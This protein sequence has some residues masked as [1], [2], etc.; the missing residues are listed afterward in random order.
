[1]MSIRACALALVLAATVTVQGADYLP[2]EDFSHED[3][4]SALTLSPDG[5]VVVYDESIRG[6]QRL[7]L[8]DLQTGQKTGI[9]LEGSNVAW[10]HYTEFYWVNN[11]RVLFYA[12]GRYAAI[13]RDGTHAVYALPGVE[14]MHLFRDEKDGN[15]LVSG[16]D[17]KVG[18]GL[19]HV[20]AYRPQRP[21]IR[22][23]NPR[24]G[25]STYVEE[26]PGNIRGWGIDAEGN[27]K[28][29]LEIRGTQYRA[30]Y[31][32]HE[33]AAWETLAGM[34]WTDP[35]VRPVGFSADGKTLY[36]TRVTPEGTWGI[37]PYDLAERRFGEVLI[38]HA[39]YDIIPGYNSISA[40][41]VWHQAP[42]YSPKERE[43]LGFRYFT[44]YPRTFWINPE[45]EQV[46]K[47]IDEAL[48]DKINTIANM[49]DDRQRML[50]V[51]WTASDPG[52]Y[53]LFDRSTGQLEKIMARRPWI[54]PDNM[55]EV[56]PIRFKARDGLTLN[57]YI[58]YPRDREQTD[59]PLVVVV[60]SNPFRRQVWQFDSTTQ[61]LANRGYAV[62]YVNT[63]GV[64]G[65]GQ[66]FFERGHR[67]LDAAI[68][69]DLADGARWAIEKGIADPNRVAIL[70]VGDISGSIALTT[71]G[72]EPD[73]FRCGLATTPFTD[74]LKVIDKGE[75]DPD[76]YA[77]LT[78]WIGDPS[79]EAERLRAASP[80]TLAPK[81]KAAVLLMHDKK[82]LDWYYNQTKAMQ[83]ALKKAG[84][85]VELINTFD[86]EKF[87]YQRHG[88]WLSGIEDFLQRN[89]A[90]RR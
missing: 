63:R 45:M 19:R 5:Q 28:V 58:A 16:Y 64:T 73:L 76:A 86:D 11:R 8:R 65:Y 55:A 68:P 18:T 44:E 39:K 37:Y 69:F 59:L 72:V 53:Y 31:R 34:D 6:D 71:L 46:Q 50:I 38:A 60:N 78:E 90:A 75:M 33:K 51:S 83:A 29:A 89:M 2:V 49:S 3:A 43:L 14:V 1:M 85:T 80:L 17:I 40:G 74:W 27:V 24:T 88:K 25:N 42:I 20:T 81:I 77:F 26:N 4:Y 79:T 30:M 15:I 62:M 41:G 10:S 84:R 54:N 70:G 36:V 32:A 87:G 82:D 66:E 61:F 48:P 67:K 23:V 35:Q 22:K 47:Q 7:F 52:K 13:D 57:G 12:H 21:F 56:Q 9:E